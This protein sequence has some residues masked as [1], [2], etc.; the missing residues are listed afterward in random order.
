VLGTFAASP[1][2]YRD[3]RFIVNPQ[4]HADGGPTVRMDAAILL[5][6]GFD[7]LDAVGPYEVV[8]TAAALGADVDASLVTVDDARRVEA[9][10]GARIAPDGRFVPDTPAEVATAL[11]CLTRSFL[12]AAVPTAG[13]FGRRVTGRSVGHEEERAGLPEQHERR[14]ERRERDD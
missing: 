11:V 4:A 9:S 13:A 1:V 8:R 5:Y 10:H 3:I 12:P 6:E 14:H 2:C 7:E